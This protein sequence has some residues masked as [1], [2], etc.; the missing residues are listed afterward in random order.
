[1]R[2]PTTAVS[3]V[4]DSEEELNRQFADFDTYLSGFNDSPS[5]H[6]PRPV[7][8]ILLQS[9]DDEHSDDDDEM[10][11]NPVSRQRS[12]SETRPPSHF[13]RFLKFH[14]RRPSQ[15]ENSPSPTSVTQSLEFPMP[16]ERRGSFQSLS[17]LGI[18][19]PI[20]KCSLEQLPEG[21]QVHHATRTSSPSPEH[22]NVPSPSLSVPFQPDKLRF[23][24]STFRDRSA[25][26][27]STDGL[28]QRIPSEL[29]H[30]TI[31]RER[32]VSFSVTQAGSPS[33]SRTPP[34]DRM[35]KKR[36]SLSYLFWPPSALFGRSR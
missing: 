6:K 5:P 19:T 21:V 29:S 2:K 8:I 36:R 22:F 10:K 12:R 11:K 16:Y 26:F 30:R 15:S 13:S 24:K 18:A 32:S 28:N 34:D 35:T 33:S 23:D 17:T 9:A 3:S 14:R 7:P 4:C 27:S 20:L 25:T 1:L 31:Q